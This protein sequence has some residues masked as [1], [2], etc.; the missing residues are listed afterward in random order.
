MLK[1][2]LNMTA[3]ERQ[4]RVT[5][6]FDNMEILIS[7]D[8]ARCAVHFGKGVIFVFSTVMTVYFIIL[9]TRRRIA[10]VCTCL[11][12]DMRVDPKEGSMISLDPSTK[13]SNGSMISLDPIGNGRSDL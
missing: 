4:R 2:T 10:T 7:I 6:I 9:T 13:F 5:N 11:L 12:S 3:V 1:L 8:L